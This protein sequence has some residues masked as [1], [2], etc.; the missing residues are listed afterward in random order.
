MDFA[1]QTDSLISSLLLARG[2]YFYFVVLVVPIAIL[3]GLRTLF[4][5]RKHHS[6]ITFSIR[7]FGGFVPMCM[8]FYFLLVL[9]GNTD[10][11]VVQTVSGTTVLICAGVGLIIGGLLSYTAGRRFEPWLIAYLDKRTKRAGRAESLT[12]IREV[13]NE[14]Q[15]LPALDVLGE[16]A[17]AASD[18]KMFLGVG[19][20][21][22]AVTID[23]PIWKSSHVQIMGP[24]GTGKGI[25]ASVALT[26]SLKFGDAVFVFDPK[27]DEWAPSVFRAA[28]QSAGVPFQYIDLN[29]PVAQVNPLL[30]AGPG[31]V[32]ELLYAGLELG[33]KGSEA[34]FYR[35]D[36]RKAA[37]L[38][39]QYA[40]DGPI[41]LKEMS[42]LAK[43]DSDRSLM[44]GAKAFYAAIDEVSE[45]QCVQTREGV[46]LAEPL[47]KGGCIYIVGSMRDDPI[48]ILQKMLFVRIIQI[49]ERTRDRQRHCSIF[50]D[51][52][53]Y[54]LSA[55]AVNT[56]GAI[57]D[58]GCNIL[59]A[60]QSLGDF[61]N[62]GAD[63]SE[64]AVRSTILDTTPIKWLYRPADHHTASWISDQTGRTLAAT[65]NVEIIRN[66]ELA[67]SLSATRSIGETERN[68][69]DV[70]TVMSLPKG[71][72][73]CIGAGIPQIAAVSA[74]RV[75]KV[76]IQPIPATVAEPAGIDLLERVPVQCVPSSDL[77]EATQSIFNL[78]AESRL[79]RFLFE[80]TWTH[81]EILRSL[82][83]EMSESTVEGMISDIA[84]RKLIRCHELVIGSS[85]TGQYWGITRKGIDEYQLI[86]GVSSNRPV[87][88]KSMLNPRSI[89]HRLDLQRLRLIAERNGW[90]NWRS[91]RPAGLLEKGE[92]YPDATVIRP[93]NFRIAMEAERSIKSKSDYT[94]IFLG[95]LGAWRKRRWD[96][97]YY[98]SPDHA[99]AN[100]LR[101]IYTEIDEVNFEGWVTAI[102]DEHRDMFR[103]FTY[104]DDWADSN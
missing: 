46:D 102:T 1:A 79:L 10:F 58:K 103:F 61:A 74:I 26:Q 72:A 88:Y 78:E 81:I 2:G 40:D 96:M 36:D 63:L 15:K 21:G 14:F 66:P 24:P 82:M 23:R 8:A 43:S 77:D 50:L 33:S 75:D 20:N 44:T 99:T 89:L 27:K 30:G 9:V 25:Q 71:C 38:A 29:E 56:L 53:K 70:N 84:D 28:C 97:I 57:R 98:L 54:L 85:S 100:R 104:D 16:S 101:Q 32:A 55:T 41:S 6:W 69:Y 11:L 18:D 67:E 59:L 42:N 17:I 47:N 31:E 22:E 48:V 91:V 7:L 12:D 68:L 49:V 65:Q 87:F 76:E 95:H 4:L 80:E 60:H 62:C 3:A 90:R 83:T 93:D 51:E 64:S 52:F 86:T 5:F 45:L 73:V 37:R 35:L 94:K 19:L 92:I 34:D 39:A 13:W